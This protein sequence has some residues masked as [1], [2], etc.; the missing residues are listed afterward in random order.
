MVVRYGSEVTF[1][2]AEVTT[3]V[4]QNT[5]FRVPKVYATFTER[6]AGGTII[7]YIVEERIPGD[8]LEHIIP[9]LDAATLESIASDISQ[10][11][12]ELSK[13][14][15]MRSRLGPIRGPWR[16]P[17]FYPLLKV[18]PCDE[19]DARTTQSFLEYV[20]R[21]IYTTETETT[22]AETACFLECFDLTRPPIFS[23]GDL[24]PGNIMVENGHVTG[25]VD[26]E[27]A[28]WYPYFWDSFVLHH[29]RLQLIRQRH[30]WEVVPTL[31]EPYYSEEARHFFRFWSA[32]VRSV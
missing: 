19:G 12:F 30:W 1:I 2:E 31:C 16:N 14:S 23:H 6:T 4:A 13:L 18:D 21:P 26:W 28:G 17:H 22:R 7:N 10:V 3:F 15:G 27:G 29:S 5:S 20:L 8:S 24:R 32:A 25:I 11:F 9:S